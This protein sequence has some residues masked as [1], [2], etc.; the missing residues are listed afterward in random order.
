MEELCPV[1]GKEATNKE[2]RAILDG[3]IYYFC[4]KVCQTAFQAEP[5]RYI[6]CCDDNK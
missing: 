2:F 3:E 4:G 5:R 1:C 6:E